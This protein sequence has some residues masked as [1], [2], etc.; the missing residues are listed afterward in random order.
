MQRKER[1]AGVVSDHPKPMAET[2]MEYARP[3]VARLPKDHSTEELKAVVVLASVIWNI[4]FIEE[5]APAVRHLSRKM[6]PRLLVEQAKAAAVIRRML[7]WKAHSFAGD[8]RSAVSVDVF[9]EGADLY[10]KAIGVVPVD[11]PPDAPEPDC[12]ERYGSSWTRRGSANR[13]R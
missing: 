12:W 10:V 6:P 8:P 2:L 5:V 7:T 13:R 4:R 3:L 9:R 11:P 1:D